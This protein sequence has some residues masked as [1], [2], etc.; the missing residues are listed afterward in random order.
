MSPAFITSIIKPWNASLSQSQMIIDTHLD[1]PLRLE[2][3]WL[4]PVSGISVQVEDVQVDNGA[5]GQVDTIEGDVLLAL[6]CGE[7]PGGHE[8]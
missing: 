6:A 1:V 3:L 7:G 4:W 2:H 8:A 5:L